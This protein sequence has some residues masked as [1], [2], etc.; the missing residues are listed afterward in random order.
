[1]RFHSFLIHKAACVDT[2]QRRLRR[3]MEPVCGKQAEPKLWDD[4][5]LNELACTHRAQAGRHIQPRRQRIG[6]QP[7]K[8]QGRYRPV[9]IIQH[10]HTVALLGN[11]IS[12]HH[13]PLRGNCAEEASAFP[14]DT[15]MPRPKFPRSKARGVCGNLI[16]IGAFQGDPKRIISQRTGCG[17][18][19]DAPL[20][21]SAVFEGRGAN[22]FRMHTQLFR[23]PVITEVYKLLHSAGEPRFNHMRRSA[24]GNTRAYL[25]ENNAV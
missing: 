3:G 25:R 20:M 4:Q 1:M 6:A 18:E 15:P 2:A 17:K 12:A 21:I 5:M 9:C 11:Q 24:V 22:S 13:K 10:D 14:A 8:D 16:R 19:S 23:I 7:V